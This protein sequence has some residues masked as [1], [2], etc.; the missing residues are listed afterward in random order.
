MRL[1]AFHRDGT[2]LPG[3]PLIFK[4]GFTDSFPVIG[5]VDGDGTREI[6]FLAREPQSPYRVTV[7]I[8][9]PD[10]TIKHT[11]IAAG[12]MYYGSQPALADLDGDGIPEIIVQ[13]NTQLNVWKGDG[14]N[15]SAFPVEYDSTGSVENSAP[16]V[17]DVDGDGEPDIVFTSYT[18]GGDGKVWVY[19]KDGVLNSH[20]PKTLPLDSGAVPA[21]ADIDLDGRNDIIVG[22]VYGNSSTPTDHVWAYDLHGA[23]YGDIE[24]GQFG[25][26]SEHSGLYASHPVGPTKTPTRTPTKTVTG[27]RTRTPTPTRTGT[28]TVTA[29]P[30]Q[31]PTQTATWTPTATATP[32]PTVTAS[33]TPSPTPSSTPCTPSKPDLISP[34]PNAVYHKNNIRLKWVGSRCGLK[35]SVMVRKGSKNGPFVVKVMMKRDTLLLKDLDRGHIYFWRVRACSRKGTLCSAGTKWRRFK[36]KAH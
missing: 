6:V 2:F 33:E 27:T 26:S 28:H 3:F 29:T 15:F 8:I 20:F 4:Y 14:S 13:T 10:G 19:S 7:Y 32:T 17:G 16:V 24:W 11:L 36:I 1:F 25:G 22:G 31:T 34:R 5:D 12:Q 35:Y 23:N 18:L 21:I 9:A 30:T